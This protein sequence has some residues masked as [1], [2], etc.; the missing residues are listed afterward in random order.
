ML[1]HKGHIND[2]CGLP[3]SNGLVEIRSPV[4]HAFHVPHTGRIPSINWLIKGSGSV[5]HAV[6]VDDC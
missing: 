6:Q 1:E 5:E 4:K 2:C 3:R